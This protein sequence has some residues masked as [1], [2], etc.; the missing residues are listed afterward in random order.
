MSIG[1]GVRKDNVTKGGRTM[2]DVRKS[3][4]GEVTR[5]IRHEERGARCE[6]GSRVLPPL[7]A[8]CRRYERIR[9]VTES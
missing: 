1:G 9:K 3:L 8:R 7:P 4:G 2:A 5:V 6:S